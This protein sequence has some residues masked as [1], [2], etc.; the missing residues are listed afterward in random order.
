[1]NVRS[2]HISKSYE[3]STADRL[4]V[5]LG[6]VICHRC[7]AHARQ[8]G[9]TLHEVTMTPRCRATSARMLGGPVGGIAPYC[10]RRFV[11][12]MEHTAL[13][14]RCERSHA[15]DRKRHAHCHCYFLNT[16]RQANHCYCPVPFWK[17][18]R[19]SR[20]VLANIY[21]AN[22]ALCR[23]SYCFVTRTTSNCDKRFP[24]C[25]PSQNFGTVQK[26]I[27]RCMDFR[28]ALQIFGHDAGNIVGEAYYYTSAQTRRCTEKMTWKMTC[29]HR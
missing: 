21:V 22:F 9:M 26:K 6:V 24:K 27:G 13:R 20:I 18:E 4:A 14:I 2:F 7:R 29:L 25:S 11:M 5:L 3:H 19:G 23:A 12:A 28:K 10:A 17:Q 8:D 16:I 15:A 1:L